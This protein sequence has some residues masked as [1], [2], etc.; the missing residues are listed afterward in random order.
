MAITVQSSVVTVCMMKSA[1]LRQDPAPM[2]VPQAGEADFVLKVSSI[3][4]T[5]LTP[6]L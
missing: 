1:M 6:M 4:F 2:V 3:R 5:L